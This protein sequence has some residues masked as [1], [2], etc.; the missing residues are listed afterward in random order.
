MS[1]IF[2][3]GITHQIIVIF[4]APVCMRFE[5]GL[6]V[7]FAKHSHTHIFANHFTYTL[8]RILCFFAPLVMNFDLNLSFEPSKEKHVLI[9]RCPYLLFWLLSLMMILMKFRIN[10]L[11]LNSQTLRTRECNQHFFQANKYEFLKIKFNYN[12]LRCRCFS[13]NFDESGK[14]LFEILLVYISPQYAVQAKWANFIIRLANSS[15]D[16]EFCKLLRSVCGF[17]AN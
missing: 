9:H 1:D 10:R 8:L 2:S 7:S 16:V 17:M 3:N 11:N 15:Y 14:K 12:L 4:L 13:R 5:I 6:S